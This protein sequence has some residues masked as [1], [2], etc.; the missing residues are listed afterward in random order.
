MPLSQLRL[1][2]VT[3]W[4]FDGGARAG[5]LVVAREWLRKDKKARAVQILE[6]VLKSFPKHVATAEARKMLETL[7]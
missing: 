3:H 2:T 1:V 7:K 4:G 6:D 5:Q